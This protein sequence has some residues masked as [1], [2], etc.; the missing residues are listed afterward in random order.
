MSNYVKGLQK[1]VKNQREQLKQQSSALHNKNIMIAEF[2]LLNE[3]LNDECINLSS[4]LYTASS[5]I[6][7]L[8]SEIKNQGRAFYGLCVL[9][10]FMIGVLITV[11]SS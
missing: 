3:S 6:K 1:Q 2:K 8:E 10:C 11:V 5:K 7:N 4:N 9:C